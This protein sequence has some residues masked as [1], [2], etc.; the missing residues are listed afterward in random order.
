ML[1]AVTNAVGIVLEA[2][3]QAD[4]V[5]ILVAQDD[6]DMTS[7]T[8]PADVAITQ[9]NFASNLGIHQIV[10]GQKVALVIDGGAVEAVDLVGGAVYTQL[11]G[12]ALVLNYADRTVLLLFADG[13]SVMVDTRTAE[14]MQMGGGWL[15]FLNLHDWDKLTIFG[16]Y[17]DKLFRSVLIVRR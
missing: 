4:S 11:D 9:N 17:D 7:Y 16:Q 13:N 15:S 2:V 14:V 12:T 8:L 10:P 5:T 6:D 1:D 3:S